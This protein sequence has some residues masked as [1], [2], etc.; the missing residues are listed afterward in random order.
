MSNSCHL[1]FT[2]M[3]A[4]KQRALVRVDVVR[5]KKEEKKGKGEEGASLSAPKAA[6]N[7]VPKRKANGKDDHPSKKPLSHLGRSSRR[8]RRRLS[9]AMGWVKT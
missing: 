1:Y 2:E 4:T 7:G 5:R 6:G 3:E 8:N 9:R